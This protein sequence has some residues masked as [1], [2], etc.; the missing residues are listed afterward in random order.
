MTTS[1]RTATTKPYYELLRDSRWQR[2]RLE[3]MERDE[4][5][6]TKCGAADGATLNVHHT[7]YI[8]GHKPW[9]YD[10]D[11][12]FTFCEECHKEMH[13]QKDKI[14]LGMC[15]LDREQ[16]NGLALLQTYDCKDFLAFLSRSNVIPMSAVVACCN[17][18]LASYNHGVA[19]TRE[20]VQ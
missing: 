6:C 19:V 2:K 14:L 17:A 16:A 12:L 1:N 11:M 10:N 15:S 3:I 9:D 13:E 4:F 8:K 20:G 5:T 18:S 7:Y